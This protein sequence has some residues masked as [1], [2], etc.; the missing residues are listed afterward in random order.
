M[1]LHKGYCLLSLCLLVEGFVFAYDNTYDNQNNLYENYRPSYHSLQDHLPVTLGN[2]H[3][4]M[5]LLRAFTSE[6]APV[7]MAR[8]MLARH[9]GKHAP[10][11]PFVPVVHGTRNRE[12]FV[13]TL[14]MFHKIGQIMSRT[15]LDGLQKK[16]DD[17]TYT[18]MVDLLC[19]CSIYYFNENDNKVK[20]FFPD[21]L[22][23]VCR[24]AGKKC[25]F[26][27]ASYDTCHVSRND[28]DY[29]AA[30]V[31]LLSRQYDGCAVAKTSDLAHSMA[32]TDKWMEHNG[33]S[34]FFVL[35]GNPRNF[36]PHDITGKTIGFLKSWYSTPR[37]LTRNK[38]KGSEPFSFKQVYFDGQRELLSNLED[39]EIDAAFVQ[40]WPGYDTDDEYAAML[41]GTPVGLEAVGDGIP[42]VDGECV[43]VRKDSPVIE[44]FNAAL[45]R[46]K[47]SGIYAKVCMKARVEHGTR[48]RIDCVV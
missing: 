5:R 12:D 15:I 11:S 1:K 43:G 13:R 48:G 7:A 4:S 17:R 20:G 8:A 26:K 36:D 40:V 47:E 16:E 35:S 45:E 6:R 28:Y 2:F 9:I 32:F 34:R 3:D 19:N 44:W 24:E 23:E 29:E 37:C 46:L 22:T 18:F 25:A 21:L 38:L 39:D 30:G 31:G 42:C 14:L 41:G 10:G 33:L 27:V